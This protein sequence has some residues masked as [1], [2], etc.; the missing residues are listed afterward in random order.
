[1]CERFGEVRG[2]QYMDL[3]DSILNIKSDPDRAAIGTESDFVIFIQPAIH[4]PAHV[5]VRVYQQRIVFS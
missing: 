3:I 1:M 5:S 2:Q 4:K